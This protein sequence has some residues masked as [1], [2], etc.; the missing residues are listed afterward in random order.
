LL[1]F[2]R[3]SVFYFQ[4]AA[5][6]TAW[7]ARFSVPNAAAGRCEEEDRCAAADRY[8]AEARTAVFPAVAADRSVVSPVAAA[9][10]TAVSLPA[11][12]P[13]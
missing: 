3:P 6:T 13:A 2:S 11:E 10:R 8:A 5:V 12:A 1:L 7:T 9:V 4:K